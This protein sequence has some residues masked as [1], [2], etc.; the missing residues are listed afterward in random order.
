MRKKLQV[1]AFRDFNVLVYFAAGHIK[2]Y[3]VNVLLR[4]DVFQKIADPE[5]FISYCTVINGT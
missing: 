5:F 1:K 3:N 4:K 2:L